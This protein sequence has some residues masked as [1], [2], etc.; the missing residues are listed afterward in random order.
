[1]TVNICLLPRLLQL[2]PNILKRRCERSGWC[3]SGGSGARAETGCRLLVRGSCNSLAGPGNYRCV[4]WHD[5]KSS[6]RPR[7]VVCQFSK[8]LRHFIPSNKSGLAE[9]QYTITPDNYPPFQGGGPPVSPRSTPVP[10][11]A[12]RRP[13]GSTP[14]PDPAPPEHPSLRATCPRHPVER[15]TTIRCWFNVGPP[16]QTVDQ[17]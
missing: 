6:Q 11:R 5:M 8:G 16:S 2:I 1:M 10:P 17:R 12:A 15:K 9:R 13:P 14:P 3:E 7:E 4:K